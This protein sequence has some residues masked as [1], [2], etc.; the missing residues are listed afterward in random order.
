M[1]KIQ[2]VKT[3]VDMITVNVSEPKDTLN[4]LSAP[5]GEP[6]YFSVPTDTSNKENTSVSCV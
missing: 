6:M 4:D 5:E 3:K 1:K 2:L